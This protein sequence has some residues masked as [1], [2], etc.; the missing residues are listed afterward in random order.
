MSASW[1]LV[2]KLLLVINTSLALKEISENQTSSDDSRIVGGEVIPLSHAP[3][4]V[5][6]QYRTY[7]IC[8]GSIISTTLVLS[9]A[10]CVNSVNPWLLT[11]RLGTDRLRAG[12]EVIGVKNLKTHP[13]YNTT[14]YSYD[15]SLLQLVKSIKLVPGVKEIISLP[16]LN[17]VV[18]DGAPALVTGWGDTKN[19]SE[20]NFFLR[21]VVIKTISRNTCKLA[22]PYLS[23]QMICAGDLAGGMD[24]CQVGFSF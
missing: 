19:V 17:E 15:F 14:S 22:Y 9:A 11:V 24:S 4:Q 16:A 18:P 7:H 8:G 3:Y 10:H 13:L 1:I 6:M 12:G 2:L 23:E 21:G 5:S 20:S